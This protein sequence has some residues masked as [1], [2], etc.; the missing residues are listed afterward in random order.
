[1]GMRLHDRTIHSRC[2]SE[3]IGIDDQ[4]PHRVSLAGRTGD[5]V[6]ITR[7]VRSFVNF[8]RAVSG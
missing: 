6:F 8:F 4:T 3:V 1:M 5:R 7:E 2:K